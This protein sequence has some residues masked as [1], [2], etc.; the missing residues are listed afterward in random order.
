LG[1]RVLTGRYFA[2]GNTACV[3]G[4]IAAGLEFYAAYPI[5]PSS[6]IAE[7]MARRLPEVGGVFVQAEDEIAAISM[8]IGA[9]A[10]GAKAMT[11]TSGPGFSLMAESVGLA[12]MLE[13]PCVIVDMMRGGPSTGQP[14]KTSQQDVMQAKWSSHGD[15]EIIALAPSTVQEI[16]DLTI[17]AFNLSERYR[18]PVILLGDAL[19][20]HTKEVLTIP[21]PDQITIVERKKPTVPPSMYLPYEAPE[22]LV[23]PLPK[24][25]EGY[26]FHMTGL[27][28]NVRGEPDMRAKAQEELVKRICDKIRRNAR[29]IAKTEA[30]MTEDAEVLFVAYGTCARML[31]AHIKRAREEGHRVGLLRLITIW[32]FPYWEVEKLSNGVKKVVVVEMNYGQILH[33]VREASKAEVSF[34]PVLGERIIRYEEVIR[35]VEG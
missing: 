17:E 35:H 7:R 31:K 19:L 29:Q 22:D 10:S 5:T 18:T 34:H 1:T 27:T 21:P 33:P 14:T 2:D 8:V 12:A 16:F 9:S 25:G 24:Y 4:A 3:E 30:F 13:I 32:P 6:E 26:L 23:P 28:H 15:Y 20:S 11:A